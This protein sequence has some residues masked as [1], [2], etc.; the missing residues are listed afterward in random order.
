MI[1]WNASKTSTESPA[2]SPAN[3]N[4]AFRVYLLNRTSKEPVGNDIAFF[5]D[6]LDLAGNT[7]SP[8]K[9]TNFTIK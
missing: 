4:Y 5:F 8:P 1:P 9:Y 3:D 2:P 7:E 6:M